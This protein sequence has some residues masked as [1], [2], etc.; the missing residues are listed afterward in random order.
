MI[1]MT[2][3][4]QSERIN[5]ALYHIHKDISADLSGKKLS[6][7]SAYSEQHF[8][9]LF[10]KITGETVHQYVLRTRLEH[11]ANQLLFDP[12]S[13][14][15][16]I[17]E[18]V[19][20]TSL[21]SFSH[22]FKREFGVTPGYWRRQE[23][24]VSP[25]PWQAEK[26]IAAAFDRVAPLPLEDPDLVELEPRQVAYVRHVGYSRSISNAWQLLKIWATTENRPFEIQ[27]GLLHSNPL[28]MPLDQCRYVACI[29][30]NQPLLRKGKINNLTIPGGIHA[31]WRLQGQYGDILPWL[32]KVYQSWLPSSGLRLKTTPAFVSYRKNHFIPPN[33]H[34]DLD[35]YL[36][37]SLY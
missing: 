14:I 7:I 11:A 30:I 3:E 27:I 10:R 34:F 25:P 23:K 19:G 2:K 15:M 29:G 12:E 6:Q 20:F 32:S 9:R 5:N 26:E 35:L 16:V 37:V 22:V 13:S 4:T 21:S 24:P 33:T 17:A 28:W 1:N 18:K 8:H 36:P 31:H